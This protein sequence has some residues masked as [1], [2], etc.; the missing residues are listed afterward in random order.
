MAIWCVSIELVIDPGLSHTNALFRHNPRSHFEV[1]IVGSCADFD[2]PITVCFKLEKIACGSSHLR[3]SCVC[4]F[5]F[6][7][8]LLQC[9]QSLLGWFYEIPLSQEY[10]SR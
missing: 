6:F 2:T 9:G 5:F 4:V 10:S 3:F 1:E 8:L 7:F